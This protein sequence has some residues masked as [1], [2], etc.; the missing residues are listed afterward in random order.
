MLLVIPETHRRQEGQKFSV[1]DIASTVA[2]RRFMAFCATSILL[3]V[4]MA[5]M[6][7]TF[8]VFAKSFVGVPEEYVGYLYTFNGILVVVLQLP[9]AAL[10]R[11]WNRALAMAGAT[12]FFVLGYFLVGFAGGMFSLMLCILIITTGEMIMSPT[13]QTIV[14]GLAP[15]A[16]VGRYMGVFGL[17]RSTGWALG[18]FIGGLAMETAAFAAD[19]RLLWA[20]IVSIGLVGAAGFVLLRKELAGRGAGAVPQQQVSSGEKSRTCTSAAD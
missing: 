3:F 20:F 11:R 18:P 6:V 16:N 8:A 1:K 17:T 4:V 12:M 2:D 7:T 9:V 10:I 13:S 5:Q 14:A 15:V 19:P